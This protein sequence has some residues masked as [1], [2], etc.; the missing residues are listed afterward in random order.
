M[1]PSEEARTADA[2]LG[3]ISL[4]EAE[5]HRVHGGHLRGIDDLRVLALLEAADIGRHRVREQF[6]VLRQVADIPPEAFLRPS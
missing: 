5:N 1:P 6:D 4:W 2:H 3:V